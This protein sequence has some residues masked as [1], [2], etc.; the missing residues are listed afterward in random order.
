MFRKHLLVAIMTFLWFLISCPDFLHLTAFFLLK[1][2]SYTWVVWAA[3]PYFSCPDL[4]HLSFLKS[5]FIHLSIAWADGILLTKYFWVTE[6][7][8]LCSI[9]FI[10][11]PVACMF[12]WYIWILQKGFSGNFWGCVILMMG[13]FQPL[14]PCCFY[15][16]QQLS[17]APSSLCI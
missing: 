13:L 11:I 3:P 16:I 14:F 8:L 12:K 17:A 1:S 6:M 2:I 10:H 9:N 15:F 4:I 5:N 7:H